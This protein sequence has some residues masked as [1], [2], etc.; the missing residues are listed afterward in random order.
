[1][2][3]LKLV[4]LLFG[5]VC[6]VTIQAQE[7]Q[8]NILL[9]CM[10]DLRPELNSF[11]VS[12]IK[13]PNIDKLASDGRVFLNHYVNSPSC[14]P[15]RYTMLTGRYGDPGNDAIF[16]RAEKLK[17]NPNS[18]PPSM[19]EWFRNKGYTTVSI[20]K[21][22]HHPGG[23]GGKDWNDVNVIEMPNAWNEQLMPVAEWEH[24]RGAMHGLANGEIRATGK[25]KM[26]VFQS[27]DGPDT[28]YPDGHI[29]NEAIKQLGKLSSQDKPFFLAVGLI[30]PHLPFG[31][32][33]KYFDLYKNVILP[34]IQSPEKPTSVS[35]WHNSSEFFQ[36][37]LWGKNPNTDKE[38][39]DE[40]RKHYAACVSYAD[41]QVGFILAKLKETGADKNT[42]I[43][44]WGDHGWNLGEHAIWGK[45]NLFEEGVRSPLIISYP[46]LKAK[47]KQSNGIVETVDI[48]PTLC[49]LS[50]IEKP[51]FANG[52]S[53]LPILKD[54][55]SSGHVAF[56]YN[57][58]ANS[59]RTMQYR[60]TLHKNGATELYDEKSTAKEAKN[61]AQENPAIVEEL[62]LLLK[63]KLDKLN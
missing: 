47:G 21:V 51:S 27:F 29:A 9:I 19:P 18:V 7:R 46:E 55:N 3:N 62:K 1:M 28:S 43:V 52:E 33:K 6:C 50:G 13:S 45:H 37:N 44:L 4:T 30:R 23:L 48:F 60:F 14:G 31:A 22:S 15:S 41:Q 8:K 17:V 24:P 5:M 38:F 11:G 20:G 58:K 10:D 53:L 57:G 40:V 2:K 12:Y 54:A 35:T 61:I 39:A 25:T 16:E 34:P 32:P 36:Y 56:S 49:D 59:I 26:D 42:I 63:N